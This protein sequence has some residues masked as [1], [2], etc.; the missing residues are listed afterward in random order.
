VIDFTPQSLAA[1]PYAISL[2]QEN[3]ARLILMHVVREIVGAHEG[4]PV[5]VSAAE[6]MRQLQNAVPEEAEFWCRPEAAVAYGDPRERI[7]Q[8]SRERGV[9]LIV[10]GVRNAGRVDAATHLEQST[11]H[12]VVARAQCPVLTV[13]A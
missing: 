4:K 6:T 10:M 13:Q 9:D 12:S 11:A 7:V 5:R 1:V 3:Q 8:V 2:A